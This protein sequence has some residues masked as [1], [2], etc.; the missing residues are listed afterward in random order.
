MKRE[1]L[2]LPN[3][4]FASDNGIIKTHDGDVPIYDVSA[5][6]SRNGEVIIEGKIDM[7][8]R[9]N[10]HNCDI[11]FMDSSGWKIVGEK[12]SI[13]N[14]KS[15]FQAGSIS[16]PLRAAFKAKGLKL[17]AKRGEIS[18]KDLVNIYKIVTDINFAGEVRVS[19]LKE[20][21]VKFTTE[22]IKDLILVKSSIPQVPRSVGYFDIADTYENYNNILDKIFD[23]LLLLFEF[24]ASNIINFPVTYISNSLGDEFIE[25]TPYVEEGGKGSSVFYLSYPG[26]L[27]KIVD[28]TYN[29]LVSLRE[30][31]DLDK[32]ILY[33]IMIKNTRFVDNSYLLCCVFMEGLKYSFAKNLKNYKTTRDKFLKVDGTS[34]S[35]K[36]LIEEIYDFYNIKKGDIGF[37]RFRNEV[38]HQGA[39]SSI[40]FKDIIVEKGK[41]EMVIEHLLLNILH[42][43]GIY[44]DRTSGEWVE[45]KSLIT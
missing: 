20:Y 26:T 19:G 12:F 22:E 11:I 10:V 27:S 6:L 35:F 25:I 24:A 8:P 7:F 15:S 41:L 4:V 13:F 45:Y 9:R 34:Y 17:V 5:Y 44:W 39:I 23:N 30:T 40:P 2:Q 42:Y 29:S 18:S 16:E 28:S 31:L 38:I 14:E 21:A 33:Y 36:E 3:I 37:I 43:D 1:L 32:L